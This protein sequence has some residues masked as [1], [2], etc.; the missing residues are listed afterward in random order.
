MSSEPPETVFELA[1]ILAIKT[2]KALSDAIAAR[3]YGE[4][5]VPEARLIWEISTGGQNIQQLAARTGT[6]K[7]FCAREVAKL[8]DA[9]Y[10]ATTPD[11]RDKRSVQVALTTAGKTLLKDLRAE[12]L[13]LEDE[14]RTQL[15]ATAYDA[16]RAAMGRLV[17]PG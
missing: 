12:K 5:S 15:G 9:G 3:G 6:T 17:D 10:L 8:R 2:R 13:R 16:F 1:Q 7:Q 14:M 4:I 11:T